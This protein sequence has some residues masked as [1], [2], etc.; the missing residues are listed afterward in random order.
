MEL[1]PAAFELLVSIPRVASLQKCITADAL[2]GDNLLCTHF[3]SPKV[4]LIVFVSGIFSSFIFEMSQYF[5]IFSIFQKRF[6]TSY[7][8]CCRSSQ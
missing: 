5:I 4:D 7:I 2:F 6:L 1:N 3:K 8:Y